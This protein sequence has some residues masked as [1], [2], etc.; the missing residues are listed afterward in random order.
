[1]RNTKWNKRGVRCGVWV[2][3][4]NNTVLGAGDTEVGGCAQ[5]RSALPTPP[6]AP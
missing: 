5:P 1:M 6:E 2:T 4:G 3:E